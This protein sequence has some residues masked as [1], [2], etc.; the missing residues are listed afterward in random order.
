MPGIGRNIFSVKTAARKGIV[1]IFDVNKPRQEAGGITVPLRGENDDLYSSKLD[2]S[3]DGYAGK[4]LSM[5][6]V[7][8]AQVWHRRLGHLNKRSLELMNRESGNGVAFDGSI[9]NCDVCVVGKAITWRTPRKLTTLPLM[10]PFSSCTEISWAPSNRRLM[11]DT[12]LSARS[13]TS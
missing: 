10:H 1:F 8:N 12:I 9:A 6:A 4:E 11:V 2:L 5:S 13:P 7:I 3:A